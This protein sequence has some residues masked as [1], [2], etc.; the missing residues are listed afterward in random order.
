[1]S[2]CYSDGVSARIIYIVISEKYAIS[3]K[4]INLLQLT[5]DVVDRRLETDCIFSQ[6]AT[7]SGR[8]THCGLRL[9]LCAR[10]Y[11]M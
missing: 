5:V 6:R 2:S 7:K 3:E 8:A 10:L 9:L 11:H 4:K 1:M